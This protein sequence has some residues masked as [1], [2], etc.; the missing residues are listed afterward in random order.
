MFCLL[1]TN[2]SFHSIRLILCVQ[3]TSEI[4]NNLTASWGKVVLCAGSTLLLTLVVRPATSQLA[5]PS[6]ITHFSYWSIKPWF[7]TEGKLATVLIIPTASTTTLSKIVWR[8]H[9]STIKLVVAFPLEVHQATDLKSVGAGELLSASVG[10]HVA[11]PVEQ[12]LDRTPTKA[13]AGF[14]QVHDR[15][16]PSGE[17]FRELLRKPS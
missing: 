4:D 13:A 11:F 5:T 3:Q 15:R 1:S 6:E 9:R 7:H 8:H 10:E 14:S 12:H 16:L 2:I 17:I